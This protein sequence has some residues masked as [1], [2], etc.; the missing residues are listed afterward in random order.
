VRIN[1]VGGNPSDA[2]TVVDNTIIRDTSLSLRSRGLMVLLLSHNTG[3]ELNSVG[4]S[5]QAKEGRD[6][7]RTAMSELE[8]AGYLRR[9][10]YR[11]E[12][13]WFTRLDVYRH[14]DAS[15]VHATDTSR[16]PGN[17]ASETQSP[18][19]ETRPGFS[20]AGLSGAI[21]KTNEEDQQELLSSPES[22]GGGV[23]DSTTEAPSQV[24][25]ASPEF[26]MWA[27][28]AL[29]S[30]PPQQRPQWVRA[31]RAVCSLVDTHWD[32]NLHLTKY[33]ARCTELKREPTPSD[34]TRWFAEDEKDA[35][36]KASKQ[37]Q[38]DKDNPTTNPYWE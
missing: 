14:G 28:A 5:K 23:S 6:A 7:V 9:V 12:G 30:A 17:P 10:Q 33:L 27:R 16:G 24:G 32:P 11:E 13:K 29:E 38:H 37:R 21:K 20:G 36:E 25:T 4:I 34:W 3:F 31:W 15:A 2:Y 1:H 26:P 19:R 22:V 35:A 18:V 8:Q